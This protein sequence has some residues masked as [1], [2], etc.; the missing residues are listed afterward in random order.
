MIKIILKIEYS[1]DGSKTVVFKTGPLNEYILPLS[2]DDIFVFGNLQNLIVG[3]D[4]D[5]VDC[6]NYELLRTILV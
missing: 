6:I 3:Q 1:V 4:I 2:R 5:S